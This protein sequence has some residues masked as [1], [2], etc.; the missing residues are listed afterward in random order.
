MLDRAALQP[1]TRQQRVI[2][3]NPAGVAGGVQLLVLVCK[4]AAKTVTMAGSSSPPP[5]LPHTY[6]DLFNHTTHSLSQACL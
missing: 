6:F 1:A 5:H 4:L 3:P 2:P